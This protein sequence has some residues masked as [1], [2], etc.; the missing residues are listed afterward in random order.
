MG[1]STIDQLQSPPVR[2]YIPQTICTHA[3]ETQIHCHKQFQTFRVFQLLF[4]PVKQHFVSV[5][6]PMTKKEHNLG[7]GRGRGGGGCAIDK[8]SSKLISLTH[9][10]NAWCQKKPAPCLR[11]KSQLH[12]S[13][14]PCNLP[15]GLAHIHASSQ[16]VRRCK[17]N[18]R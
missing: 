16:H 2:L 9:G 3:H 18:F 1:P 15:S 5:H 11:A 12:N 6:C 10:V 7:A 14:S 13:T 4:S 17:S 8:L